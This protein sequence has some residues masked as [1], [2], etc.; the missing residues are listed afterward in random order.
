MEVLHPEWLANPVLVEKQQ[1][2]PNAPVVWR[3]CIDYTDLNKACPKDHFPLP[4]IDQVIDSTA[5]C[6]L[7]SFIDAIVTDQD[8]AMR[9]TI[10]EIFK[11]TVHKNCRWHIMQ[12]LE[13]ELGVFMHDNPGVLALFEDCI[14]NSLSPEEFERKWAF[15][16]EAFGRGFTNGPFSWFVFFRT[17]KHNKPFLGN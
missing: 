16:I 3:M 11:E 6:E 13:K 2:D 17:Y 15:M 9:T 7:L 12:H 8:I 10:D 14:N 4:R 5:G 1:E